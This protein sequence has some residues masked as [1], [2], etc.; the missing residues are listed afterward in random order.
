MYKYVTMNPTIGITTMYQYEKRTK[1]NIF[2][3]TK[4]SFYS[5]IGKCRWV[6]ERKFLK[7]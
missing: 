6:K 2:N 1:N 7:Y 4:Q 3:I 5:K